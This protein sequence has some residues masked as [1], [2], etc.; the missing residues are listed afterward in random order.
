MARRRKTKWACTRQSKGIK[1]N[2]LNPIR[3]QKCSSC[4]KPKPK[5]SRPKHMAALNESYE[6]YLEINGGEHCGMCGRPPTPGRRLDRDH[7]HVGLG[8]PRGLLCVDCNRHLGHWYTLER[9]EAML[10]YLR[11]HRD[12]MAESANLT[13]G[14]WEGA[15]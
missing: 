10:A 4:G 7:D 11:R 1:C 12:R 3:A 8:F 14:D 9:V 2:T 6:H 15:A 13:D 5:P